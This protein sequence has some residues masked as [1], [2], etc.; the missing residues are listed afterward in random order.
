M[1]IEG[2]GDVTAQQLVRH[3]L[4]KDYGDIYRIPK[5]SLLKL[6]RMGDK[7]AENLLKGIEDSKGRGLSRLIFGLGIRHVGATSAQALARHFGSLEKLAK[8]DG[9]E[10]TQLPEVGPVVAASVAQFFRAPGTAPVLQKLKGAGV[11][12]EETAPRLVS[13]R[14]AGQT[15]VFTG[16]LSDFPRPKAEELVREH[17]GV[18]GSSVTQK[19]TLVVVGDSPGSKYEKAKALGVKVVDE[20]EFKR[21]IRA[22]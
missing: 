20:H 9:E 2:L 19:T 16:E 8:A 4:V 1:D 3:G 13:K 18:V 21:M 14:L 5:D 22:K 11:G 6:E 17:G 10:L 7:S 15:V 12:M